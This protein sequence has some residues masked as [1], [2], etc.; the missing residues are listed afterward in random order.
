MNTKPAMCLCFPLL[1]LTKVHLKCEL[2]WKKIL[3][4]FLT[5]VLVTSIKERPPN[6]SRGKP[7]GKE[8][9]H[10]KNEHKPARIK[11]R[12][13]HISNI[14]NMKRS[15]IHIN[16]HLSA[17]KQHLL[18]IWKSPGN[19]KSLRKTLYHSIVGNKPV[20]LDEKRQS[21]IYLK[22]KVTITIA[23]IIIILRV[24]SKKLNR[25]LYNK[26]TRKNVYCRMA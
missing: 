4:V 17:W 16:G 13:N 8:Q 5:K 18:S 24:Y 25:Y 2:C 15:E 22:I 20:I 23:P 9:R 11:E 21:F 14:T 3:A 1:F 10:F 7:P 12:A 26:S 19:G 6:S